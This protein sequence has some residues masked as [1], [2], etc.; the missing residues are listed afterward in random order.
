MG[1][2]IEDQVA[3]RRATLE[4][5]TTYLMAPADTNFCAVLDAMT[6]YRNAYGQ[7]A[8]EEVRRWSPHRVR[9]ETETQ[10]QKFLNEF[11]GVLDDLKLL[12]GNKN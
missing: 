5:M 11:S 2:A 9:V 7:T 3:A 10:A 6:I 12:L 1:E 4:A 8:L